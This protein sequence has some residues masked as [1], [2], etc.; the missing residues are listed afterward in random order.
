MTTKYFD[1]VISR[2][3]SNGSTLDGLFYKKLLDR[4]TVIVCSSHVK[5]INTSAKAVFGK[6]FW[7]K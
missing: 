7:N 1:V 3:F 6:P 4:A 5:I 2:F